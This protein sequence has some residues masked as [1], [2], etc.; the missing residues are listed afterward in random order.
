MTLSKLELL[1]IRSWLRGATT[2]T[3]VRI[4]ADVATDDDRDAVMRGMGECDHD[5]WCNKYQDVVSL[6]ACELDDRLPTRPHA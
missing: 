5:T 4:I 3:L 1:L 6:A 2:T